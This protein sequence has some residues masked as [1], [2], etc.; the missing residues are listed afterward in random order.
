MSQRT[1]KAGD[2]QEA[3]SHFEPGVVIQ[4]RYALIRPLG[5][6][7]AGATFLVE[8][9][10]LGVELALKVLHLSTGVALEAFRSEFA[11]LSGLVHPNLSRVHDFGAELTASG[12]LHFYTAEYIEGV[13]LEQL[14]LSLSDGPDWDEVLEPFIDALRAL[15]F[16]H[17]SVGLRHGD[18]KPANIM[19]R[20]SGHGV[21][22]DLGCA[23]ALDAPASGQLS[24]T[25]KYFAPELI[26]GESAGARADLYA[27]GVTL[28][29]LLEQIRGPRAAT[30][31][32]RKLCRRLTSERPAGRPVEVLEVL[33]L[34]GEGSEPWL[35]SGRAP[36]LIGRE[37][38]LSCFEELLDALLGGRD[39]GRALGISGPPGVGRSRLLREM[40]WRA[41]LRCSVIEGLVSGQ[42]SIS[43]LLGRIP[44]LGD[45]PDGLDG[46]FAARD[47][48]I[49]G[50]ERSVVVL[51]DVQDL[52]GQQRELFDALLRVLEP[53]VPVLLICAGQV[54]PTVT[55]SWVKRLA[56]EPLGEL[57]LGRWVFEAQAPVERRNLPHLA[58]VTGGFPAYL[59]VFLSRLATG[60]LQEDELGRRVHHPGDLLALPA[61]VGAPPRGS[62]EER[63]ALGLVAVLGGE[64]DLDAQDRLGISTA[65]L[66]R[67]QGRGLVVAH[68][69]AW[70]LSRLADAAVLLE[71]FDKDEVVIFHSEA[72][73]FF[74][75]RVRIEG[76]ASSKIKADL[77]FH[78]VE[79]GQ[80]EA[81]EEIL[82]ASE[83]LVLASP[84]DWVCAATALCHRQGS[85]EGQLTAA[86]INQKA[87]HPERALSIVEALL[88]AKPGAMAEARCELLAGVCCLKL[89]QIEQARG[90]LER[91]LEL[92]PEPRHRAEVADH[93]SRVL[94]Q[95]GDYA[96]ALEH[97]RGA[98]SACDD[99]A[100]EA[101]LHECAGVASS[102]LGR[103]ESARKHLR[104]AAE[105][106]DRAGRPRD[107]VR[108]RSYLAIHKFRQGDLE[109]AVEGY[110][111]ALEI[112]Q[113]HGLSDLVASAALNLGTV[114]QQRG[115]LGLAME[116]YERGLRIAS[117]LG[118]VSTEV[119]LRF[120]LANLYAAI[121]LFHRAEGAITA[122]RERALAS[123][124]KYFIGATAAV[125]GEIALARGH[126]DEAHQ[127]FVE[128]RKS[129]ASQRARRE[130]SEQDLHLAEVKL[131]RGDLEAAKALVKD[132]LGPDEGSTASDLVIKASLIRGEILIEEG[133]G[134]EAIT[135]LEAALG[136]AQ[137]MGQRGLEGEIATRLSR[138]CEIQG[139]PELAR[140][141]RRRARALWER[142]AASLP[143]TLRK[144]FWRHPL[145]AD[146]VRAAHPAQDDPAQ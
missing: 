10:L 2:L 63:R 114:C 128:A 62:R 118:K 99:P 23:S 129:Y 21:L 9:R 61:N 77:T 87:G 140:T 89:G 112:A 121:G 74:R 94:I 16:L 91:G 28:R 144:E 58:R 40:K 24:G 98:L 46:V 12:P 55:S 4:G 81:A 7:G 126:S 34:L 109:A 82:R 111:A 113:E 67:L 36:R 79:A 145:R 138:A 47:R 133:R 59:E 3:F 106:H 100:Q 110:R 32:L 37:A 97:A 103:S 84:C 18:F 33:D 48:L 26:A 127:W 1:A 93:L 76:E 137:G 104:L 72:A 115:D 44:G 105:H 6:G 80:V 69:S 17:H 73:A 90:H 117:A 51:D 56:L 146:L 143:D 119:S 122:T 131:L 13:T 141:H 70:S 102:Y 68:G 120:N 22:I 95:S 54:A 45:L 139:A 5:Q 124:L 60:E 41:Q 71:R 29:Q 108:V 39:A 53:A 57:E 83:V 14:L 85:V 19:V 132:T 75:E 25:P 15:A 86:E 116:S 43:S 64:L 65:V 134:A 88:K 130:V 30:T 107:Q 92:R 135:A 123:G 27:V 66:A 31:N 78:L 125:L 11:R 101:L 136:K 42:E 38:E 50:E 96:E 20:S 8:D 49:N 52:D 142:M 35:P